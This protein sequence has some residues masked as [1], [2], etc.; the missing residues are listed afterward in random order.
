MAAQF[1]NSSGEVIGIAVETRGD[2]QNLNFAIP[3]N[4]L[5]QLLRNMGPVTPLAADA[6]STPKNPPPDILGLILLSAIAFCVI[7]FLPTVN[8]EN[9]LITIGIAIGLGV[10]KTLII[11]IMTHP[12]LPTIAAETFKAFLT[13]VP[14]DDLIHALEECN[15]C[16]Q[17]L[18][19][20]IVKLPVYIVGTAFLLGI[21]NKAV[22]G[23][24]LEG[25][26]NTFFVAILI[27]GGEVFVRWVTPWV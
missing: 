8:A 6:T 21:A 17:Q 3:V 18:L 1:L 12:A 2:G 5:K 14:P 10:I 23:F 24:K 16:F 26:F 7:K 22:P 4:F 20:A 25:F 15:N 13:A 11:A 9:L 27:V 19:F